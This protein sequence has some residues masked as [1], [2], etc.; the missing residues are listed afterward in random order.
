MQTLEICSLNEHICGNPKLIT[1]WRIQYVWQD[2]CF[3]CFWRIQHLIG[4]IETQIYF[5]TLQL[6]N[7]DFKVLFGKSQGNWQLGT[8]VHWKEDNIKMQWQF[9]DQIHFCMATMSQWTLWIYMSKFEVW[10]SRKFLYQLC[11]YECFKKDPVI[12]LEVLWKTVWSYALKIL[13]ENS[14][15][16]ADRMWLVTIIFMYLRPGIEPGQWYLT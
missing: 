15:R 16:N 3:P 9:V 8:P 6:R 2:L 5:L 13:Q 1:Y 12:Y 4:Y 14:S 11:S 7:F 10:E